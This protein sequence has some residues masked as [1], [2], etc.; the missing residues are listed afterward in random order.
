[1]GSHTQKVGRLQSVNFF[2]SL[3]D[4]SLG[5]PVFWCWWCF[6]VLVLV[7]FWCFTV[8][9]FWLR[10][11]LVFWFSGVGGV[12]VLVVLWRWRFRVLRVVV[13]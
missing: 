2:W 6:G 12:L 3:E 8:L 7:L 5:V 11:V 4:L 1:M 10:G 13:F 9:A